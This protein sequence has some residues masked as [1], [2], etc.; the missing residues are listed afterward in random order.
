MF[1]QVGREMLSRRRFSLT[2]P[3]PASTVDGPCSCH[4][5]K[6]SCN[7]WVAPCLLGIQKRYIAALSQ[8]SR[9][10]IRKAGHCGLNL[11]LVLVRAMEGVFLR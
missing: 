8:H 3:F 7:F 5:T 2:Q 10:A 9:V 1:A 6:N 11:Q 4:E